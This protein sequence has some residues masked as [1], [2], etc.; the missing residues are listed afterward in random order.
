MPGSFQALNPREKTIQLVL[1]SLP[2]HCE[3]LDIF[4]Y[5]SVLTVLVSLKRPGKGERPFAEMF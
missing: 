1:S 3:H 2:A 5:D 4:F